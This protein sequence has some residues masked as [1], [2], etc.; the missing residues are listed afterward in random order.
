[1]NV[2]N[3]AIKSVQIYLAHMLAHAEMVSQKHIQMM[4][5][6][7]SVHVKTRSQDREEEMQPMFNCF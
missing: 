7:N 4:P 6:I 1:M 5:L 2:P 3:H